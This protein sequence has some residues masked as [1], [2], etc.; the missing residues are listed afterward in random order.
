MTILIAT[1]TR[2]GAWLSQDTA[3]LGHEAHAKMADVRT[4]EGLVGS[5]RTPSAVPFAYSLKVWPAPHVG[6][7]IGGT[8]VSAP[9]VG[10]AMAVILG[11]LADDIVDLSDIAPRI[12]RTMVRNVPAGPVV[13][14]HVGWSR[15]Q[16]RFVGVLFNRETDFVPTPID[17]HAI[18]PMPATDDL[19]YKDWA[20]RWEGATQG[21]DVEAFHVALAKAQVRTYR[22]GL[23]RD[24]A[25][26]GGGVDHCA[27]RSRWRHTDESCT[28]LRRSF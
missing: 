13:I 3:A 27:G 25:I 5:G 2:V 7:I 16:D 19:D 8:G 6:M 21:K 18:T 1:V 20:E 9:I 24:G 26:L 12:L 10:W 23:Y 15:K 28:P 14:V 17:G 11:T 4:D 22:R